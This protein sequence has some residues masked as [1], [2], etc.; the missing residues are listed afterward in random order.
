MY[1]TFQKPNTP[2]KVKQEEN[3][4]AAEEWMKIGIAS[5]SDPDEGFS[6]DEL[7][8]PEEECEDESG[9]EETH[10]TNRTVKACKE[11]L[12]GRN[13][14]A[15]VDVDSDE[16]PSFMLLGQIPSEIQKQSKEVKSKEAHKRKKLTP[17]EKLKA[18]AE[19]KVNL[20]RKKLRLSVSGDGVPAP[21]ESFEDLRQR[22]G[23]SSNLI[24]NLRKS[25]YKEPTPIQSQT[26]PIMLKVCSL[27]LCKSEIIV[28]CIF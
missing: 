14:N 8:S 3:F 11:K 15:E 10:M 6:P 2:V 12:N 1:F 26:W 28:V 16:D 9:D 13:V 21:V 20:L 24:N 22:Y 23:V 19:E 4:N 5:D 18:Q 25:G 17:E 7:E 27:L